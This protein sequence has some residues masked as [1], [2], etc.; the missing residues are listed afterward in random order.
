MNAAR[1]MEVKLQRMFQR[2]KSSKSPAWNRDIGRE[3]MQSMGT[4]LAQETG[5]WFKA[6]TD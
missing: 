6:F 2:E 3:Y 1:C 5:E 4:L